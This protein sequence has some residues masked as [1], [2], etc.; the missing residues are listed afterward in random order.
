MRAC[1][2]QRADSPWLAGGTM[3]SSAY[4]AA[5]IWWIAPFASPSADFLPGSRV[6]VPRHRLANKRLERLLVDLRTLTDEAY[7]DFGAESAVSLVVR[8][9]HL[10]ASTWKDQARR[11]AMRE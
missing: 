5:K 8:H 1:S 10:I 3:M 4:S 7:V 2:T 6:R 9:D 11:R